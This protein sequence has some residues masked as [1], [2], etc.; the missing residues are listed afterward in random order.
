VHNRSRRLTPEVPEQALLGEAF[1]DEPAEARDD[2]AAEAAAL[3]LGPVTLFF[4]LRDESAH[5]PQ[6]A[7]HEARAMVLVGDVLVR[8]L[9]VE[10]VLVRADRD[11]IHVHARSSYG[12]TAASHAS[13]DGYNPAVFEGVLLAVA[14][15][16]APDSARVRHEEAPV[17]VEFRLFD[18]AT[19]ITSAATVRVTHSGV[20]ERGTL[21]EG[22]ELTVDLLPGIYDAEAMCQKPGA[23]RA[24]RV[25]DHRVVMAYPDEGG[26]HVEVINFASGFGALELRW[27]DAPPAD[28][29]ATAITISRIGGPHAI[30]VRPA[31]GSGY[32]LLVV[33]ADT[34]DVRVTRPGHD[35]II[36]SGVQIPPDSTRLKL[37]K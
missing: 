16:S 27:A 1:R 2:P 6:G 14:L 23:T 25:A 18:G 4:V 9:A 12:S 15:G 30:A 32:L 31:R 17:H 34:Y 8:H 11:Q 19:E 22:R 26:R 10:L 7:L 28:A 5:A 3:R 36:L 13:S 33:P 24:I 29:A 35:P 37:L 21:L 20:D